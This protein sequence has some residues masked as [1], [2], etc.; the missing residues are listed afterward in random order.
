MG[1]MLF[2]AGLQFGDPPEVWNVSQAELV[3]RIHGAYHDAGSQILMTNTFGCNRLRLGLHGLERRVG[4]LNQTA[5]VLL[6]D[7]VDS[8]GGHALVAGGVDLI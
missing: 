1:T 3:R 6:R 2:S 7:E 8:R 4:E 5:A